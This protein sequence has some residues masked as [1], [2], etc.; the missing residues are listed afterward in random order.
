MSLPRTNAPTV[1]ANPLSKYLLVFK[2]SPQAQLAGPWSQVQK[3]M[4]SGKLG[5]QPN[6]PKAVN[7]VLNA[8]SS[9]SDLGAE[10]DC[11]HDTTPGLLNR[12]NHTA[13]PSAEIS[14]HAFW[15]RR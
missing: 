7:L 6:Y 5:A 14:G 2:T 12:H 8:N 11:G 1:L 10:K 9:S 4:C 13:C 15:S 3:A